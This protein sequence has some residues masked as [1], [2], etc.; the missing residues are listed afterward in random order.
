PTVAASAFVQGLAAHDA[1][2][3]GNPVYMGGF[4]TTS[5]E[6]SV[7]GSGDIVR[8]IT[9]LQGKQVVLPYATGE[10]WSSFVTSLITTSADQVLLAGPGAGFRYYITTI[11][12]TAQAL[13]SIVEIKDSTGANPP[14]WRG[15][16]AGSGGGFSINPVPP[17]RTT[18]NNS[19]VAACV[20]SGAGAIFC[21]SAFK[22]P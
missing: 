9:D 12:V 7:V 11:M 15:M 22:A 1:A 6:T 21:I 17:I 20:T 19:I 18:A 13:G 4:A 2:A 8:L 5:A 3:V 16:A 10:N 14:L